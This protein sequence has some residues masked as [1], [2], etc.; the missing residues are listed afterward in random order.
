M[1]ID[2]QELERHPVDFDQDFEPGAIDLGGDLRQRAGL[3]AAGRA[4][5][6]EEHDGKH[7]TI[8]DI[9]LGGQLR[10]TLEMTCARCLEPV[11]QNVQR[12]FELL[13][14]PLGTDAGR[15][16]LSVTG[17]EAEIGYYSG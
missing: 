2:I 14:R 12:E 15:A 1:F 4:Q 5:L 6:V 9:R 10:T 16:E 8:K 11:V 7:R 17:A 3:H 13:Y